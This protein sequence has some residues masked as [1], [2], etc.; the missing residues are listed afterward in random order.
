DGIA[1]E[2]IFPDGV[3]EMN[4]PPFGSGLAPAD[5]LLPELHW[6]G[7]RAHNRWI[8]EFCAESPERRAGLAIVPIIFDIQE[9]V[10]EIRWARENGLRGIMIPTMWGSQPPYHHPRYEPI[11]EVCADLDMP[12]HTH[13]GSAPDFGEFPG[14]VG[15]YITEVAWWSTRPVWFLIWSGVFERHP[16]LKFVVTELGANWVPELKAL[17]DQ[18]FERNHFTAKLAEYRQCLKMKPSE[19][20]DR[21]CWVGASVTTRADI[22]IRDKIGL[23]NIM[24]G[25]DFPHPEGAWPHTRK[26]LVESFH[27]IPERDTRLMLGE[28]AAKVYGFDLEKLAPLVARIGPRP[29]EI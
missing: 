18:R 25:S 11:W 21:N 17:M 10:R 6:A 24:W 7:A 3:T 22:E 16:K 9:A 28:N 5:D 2:I 27:G 15:I 20:F 29:R 14:S 13:G 26:F 4:V 1:G 19:Y 12:V 23:G 8:A